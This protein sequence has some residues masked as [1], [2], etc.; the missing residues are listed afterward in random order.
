VPEAIVDGLIEACTGLVFHE[1]EM[2]VERA[3]R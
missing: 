3:K 1:R 2:V